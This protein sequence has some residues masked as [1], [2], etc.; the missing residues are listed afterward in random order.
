MEP[1]AV[2]SRLVRFGLFELDMQTAELSKNGRKLKLQEQPFRLLALLLE[3]P[4]E[5]VT[6]ERLKGALW[7]ED[8]FVDFEHSLN[9]AVAK[10]RQTLGDP[11]ENPRFIA[12]V[13]R[14]GYR[15][16]APVEEAQPA[17]LE[18]SPGHAPMIVGS[19]IPDEEKE[20]RQPTQ[21]IPV[22]AITAGLI[23]L[24]VVPRATS[25]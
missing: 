17:S 7:P 10:L 25:L 13:P 6:R 16:I 22:L 21:G 12:T 4:G 8:T 23:F 15:F 19:A 9:A 18:S 20:Q 24:G 2:F 3:H 14:R 11:A 1:G 5:V